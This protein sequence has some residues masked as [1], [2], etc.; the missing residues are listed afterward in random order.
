M[1]YQVKEQNIKLDLKIATDKT[2]SLIYKNIILKFDRTVNV[3]NKTVESNVEGNML[4]VRVLVT[5][6]ENIA[7]VQK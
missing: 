7:E 4:K 6:E 1:Y 3:I 5:A 2:S